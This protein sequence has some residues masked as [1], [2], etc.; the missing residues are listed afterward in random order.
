MCQGCMR[1]GTCLMR[2][3]FAPL[4]EKWLAADVVIY[5]V[6][7]YHMGIPGAVPAT[8]SQ[9][10]RHIQRPDRQRPAGVHR[11]PSALLA[12]LILLPQRAPPLLVERPAARSHIAPAQLKAFLDRLGNSSFGRYKKLFGEDVVTVP[13]IRGSHSPASSRLLCLSAQQHRH[14]YRKNDN[15]SVYLSSPC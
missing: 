11:H 8:V 13:R 12:P 14:Q 5:S 2:D 1:D 10:H 9:Q 3:D 15:E 7:V 6:P 4:Q